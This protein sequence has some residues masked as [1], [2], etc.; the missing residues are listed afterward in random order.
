[1]DWTHRL[2]TRD[3]LP[4]IVQLYNAT[5]PSRMVTADLEAV[6]V[7]SRVGWF[8]Q[9]RPHF[10]PLWVAE[11]HGRIAGWLSFSVFYGRP[12]YNKTAELSIYV[13]E[14]VRGHGLGSYFLAHAISHAPVLGVDRLIGLIFGHNQPS[15]KLFEKFEFERWGS[16]PGVTLLDGVER[17]VII[18]GRKLTNQ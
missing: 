10:R 18:V 14:A 13:D 17:D 3:D 12:A 7:E 5:I 6:P 4:A 16:L 9:H 15:L 2:A 11:Q 1:M 8:E